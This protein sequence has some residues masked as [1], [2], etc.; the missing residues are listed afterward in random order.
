MLINRY[1]QRNIFLG[2]FAVLL[3]LVSLNLF[4]V[5]VRELED[6]GK[7][8]YDLAKLIEYLVLLMPGLIVESMPLAVLLGC[9]LN[10]GALASNGEIIAMQASGVSAMRLLGSLL[11]AAAVLAIFSLLLA[12]W[13][14]PDSSTVARHLKN[15]AERPTAALQSTQG[16]WL[17]DEL[18]VIHIDR[19]LPNGSALNVEIFQLDKSDKPIWVLHA[20]S[21]IP[22]S[23]GWALQRVS[24]TFFDANRTR[25]EKLDDLLYDGQISTEILQ[26][27]MIK[28]SRMSIANLYEYLYFL[29]QNGLGS[30]SERVIFWQKVLAPLS[31]VIMSMLAFPFVLGVQRQVSTGYRILIGI[32]LGLSFVVLTRLLTQIGSQFGVN[33]L[34]IALLPNLLFLTLA[35][36]LL[37][38]RLSHVL[39][40]GGRHRLGQ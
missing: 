8:D 32:L 2:V 3:V 14:V 15:Q 27:L 18:R 7:G 6:L 10:L 16:L 19:L 20:V 37:L 12:E 22:T 4:F 30:D 13:V 21:A 11:Q 23:K 29:D 17:K 24:R 34:I 28:P 40:F 39:S 38:K 31:I 33:A 36:I 5:L 35:T 25:T 26:V 1:L 9:I